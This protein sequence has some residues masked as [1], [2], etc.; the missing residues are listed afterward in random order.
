MLSTIDRLDSDRLDSKVTTP[1]KNS[2]I[3]QI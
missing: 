2:D 3:N 1:K